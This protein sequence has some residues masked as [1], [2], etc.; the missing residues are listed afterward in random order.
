M[1]ITKNTKLS[2]LLEVNPKAAEI[3]FDAGLSCVGCPMMAQETIG[4]GCLG[5]GMNEKEIDEL[6]EK[7]NEK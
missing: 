3:L 4:Q 2:K 1:K 6:L 7:L 5:H